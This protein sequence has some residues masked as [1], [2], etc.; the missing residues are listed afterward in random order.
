MHRLGVR[1][2]EEHS[3]DGRIEVSE[4]Q[5]RSTHVT[6]RRVA[7][8]H[9]HPSRGH[10][11]FEAVLV[12]VAGVLRRLVGGIVTAEEE[13]TPYLGVVPFALVQ[14]VPIDAPPPGHLRLGDPF[15]RQLLPVGD[16]RRA[17][18]AM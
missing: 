18:T 11:V 10:H 15:P 5:H 3:R 13:A 9:G 7:G 8:G 2:V 16:G 1:R 12:G 6:G 17:S 14:V 4:V